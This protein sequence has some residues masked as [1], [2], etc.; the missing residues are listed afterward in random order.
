MNKTRKLGI[1]VL[2]VVMGGVYFLTKQIKEDDSN[3]STDSAF[4][5][6]KDI[7]QMELDAK[8]QD[9]IDMLRSSLL[10]AIMDNEI[11]LVDTSNC[12][13]C[14]SNK[15]TTAINGTGW[16][17]FKPLPGKEGLTKYYGNPTLHI[18]PINSGDFVYSFASDGK[19]FEINATLIY[20]KN[21]QKMRSDGGNNP[22][23]LEVGTNLELLN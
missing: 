16:I 19:T 5:K 8:R 22:T 21:V 15:G 18:D 7:N 6:N 3:L 11:S 2:L 4:N 9:D 13:D 20:E 14:T 12:Q 23:K 17:K 1:L 10:L